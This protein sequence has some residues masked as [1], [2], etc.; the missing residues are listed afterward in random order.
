[1]ASIRNSISLQDHMTPVLKS[2]IRSMDNTLRVMRTLDKEANKGAQSRAF[3]AAEKNIKKAN[4]ELTKMK[5]NLDNATSSAKGLS[6]ATSSISSSMSGL[7]QKGFNLTNLAAGLYL[8]KSAA[9]AASSIM[10]TPDTMHAIQYRLDTYDTTSATGE[11]L[12]DAAYLAAQRSR[13]DL[14]STANLASRIL[15]S[16]ATGGSGSEAIKIAETL[17]KAS[18]LGGSS[19]GESQRAVLQLSQALASGNLQGDELRAIR[20]QAP[21]LTDVLSKG[22]SA[23]ADKGALPDK[24]KDTVAGDLK[25]LGKEGELTAARIIAAFQEMGEEVDTVFEDS[26]KQFGQAVTGIKNVWDRWL[27]IMSSGDNALARINDL[28]WQLL[29]WLESSEGEAFLETI[30]NLLN[31]IVDIF[32]EIGH[33]IGSVIN[34]FSELENSS[35]LVE[36]ALTT[37]GIV[38]VG[39]A[40]AWLAAWV[41]A[42]WPLLLI[43]ILIGAIVTFLKDLGVTSE[44]IAEVVGGVIG[45]IG[46]LLYDIIIAA[47]ITVATLVVVIGT[48]VTAVGMTIWQI[49]LWIMAGLITFVAFLKTLGEDIGMSLEMSWKNTISILYDS[50]SGLARSVLKFLE[51][52]AKGIDAVF[53]SNLADTVTGWMDKLDTVSLVMDTALNTEKDKD[54]LRQNWINFAES[55]KELWEA[56][57]ITKDIKNVWDT[58]FKLLGKIGEKASDAF[59][60]PMEGW[61][62]GKDFGAKLVKGLSEFDVK[63]IFNIEDYLPDGYMPDE[64]IFVKGGDLDSVGRIKSDVNISDED[65]KLL[66]DITAR[67]FLLNLQSV[68]PVANITFGDIKE[69]ADVDQILDVIQDMVDEQLATSLVVG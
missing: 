7:S 15:I 18:F 38:A 69:T 50:F 63:D 40:V 31:V 34:W 46:A 41:I 67:D 8:L 43:I 30:A 3:I 60:D 25:Q 17:N 27:K 28:A 59:V 9:N 22:L 32:F 10:E 42:N 29:D 45:F 62:K 13:S 55:T 16:G 33:A 12:F 2:I 48:I 66:R 65:L 26:P 44:D 53:G 4:N 64:N 11:Q 39:V 21:G 14:E 61:D 35:E 24:F 58:G 57:N 52:I 23:L 68:T 51:T 5:N 47:L 1:M 37:L 6:S 49:I 36:I 19:A 20:E 56:G 54:K